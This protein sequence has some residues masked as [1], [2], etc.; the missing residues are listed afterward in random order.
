MTITIT[1][2]LVVATTNILVIVLMRGSMT[3]R[4]R[5]D[6]RRQRQEKD[7]THEMQFLHGFAVSANLCNAFWQ[8]YKGQLQDRIG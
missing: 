3:S 7:R 5:G 6:L 8:I 4:V 1:L 2:I